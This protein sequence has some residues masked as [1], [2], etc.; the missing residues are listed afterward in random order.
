MLSKILKIVVSVMFMIGFVAQSEAQI[1]GMIVTPKR[2][3]FEENQRLQELTLANRGDQAQTYRISL[4][5]RQMTPDG[6]LQ[7]ATQPAAGEFFATNVLRYGPRQITLEPRQTQK[8]RLMSR[9]S[10]DAPD[11]EYRS[12]ILVQEIPK[13][14]DAQQ[15]DGSSE[16]D[17]LGVNI[18]SIYGISVP[19][20]I[21]KGALDAAL[22]LSNPSVFSDDQGT[23]VKVDI[24]RS[25]NKSVFGSVK[26]FDGGTQ[27]ALL[28]GV[29][30]YLS[31]PSR[32]VAVPVPEA[33]A[34][35]LSGKTL[36]VTYGAS[37]SQEDAPEV[38]TTFTVQ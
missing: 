32:T 2:I 19:V 18:S 12:H 26:V 9:L 20:F 38:E 36:R 4:V 13:A 5:N 1:K 33:F 10:A 30:V 15:S 27:I 25:G 31:S 22:S 8:V 11:G 21:R 16:S 37:E 35:S 6:N 34:D 29:A 28:K 24:E 7:P 3:V 14:D 23:Y 17:T